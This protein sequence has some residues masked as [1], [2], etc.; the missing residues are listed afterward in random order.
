MHKGHYKELLVWQQSIQLVEMVYGICKMLPKDEMFAL[1]SQLRRAAVSVASNIAEGSGRGTAKEFIQHLRIAY[2]SLC[3]VETQLIIVRRLNLA[4]WDWLSVE[5]Q[6]ASI[7]RLTRA[8]IRSLQP[9]KPLN[10]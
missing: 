1:S 2:G 8:L 5:A 10:L 9:V 4:Q 3:E 7:A 6:T